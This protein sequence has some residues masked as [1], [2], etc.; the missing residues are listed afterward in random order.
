M[1]NEWLTLIKCAHTFESYRKLVVKWACARRNKCTYLIDSTSSNPPYYITSWAFSDPNST[2]IKHDRPPK[3]YL[4]VTQYIKR[5]MHKD[6]MKGTLQQKTSLDCSRNYT[7]DFKHRKKIKYHTNSRQ[8]VLF[9]RWKPETL[10]ETKITMCLLTNT[11]KTRTRLQEQ[12]RSTSWILHG[13]HMQ[14]WKM[15]VRNLS[16]SWLEESQN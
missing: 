6:V 7:Y 4:T 12:W 8:H 3:K 2:S 16:W 15:T 5:F 1:P 14:T 10:L 11:R 13:L 9:R